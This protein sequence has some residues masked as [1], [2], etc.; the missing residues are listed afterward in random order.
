MQRR[1]RSL[2]RFSYYSLALAIAAIHIT[3]VEV[4]GD[5]WWLSLGAVVAIG[6]GGAA[7][8]NADRSTARLARTLVADARRHRATAQP[9]R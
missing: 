5:R 6:V 1:R 7:A 2:S 9:R 8:R 4:F 3:A